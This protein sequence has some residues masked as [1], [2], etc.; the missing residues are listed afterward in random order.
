MDD[1]QLRDHLGDLL[2]GGN[3]HVDFK[4][5]LA[6]IPPNCEACVRPARPTRLEFLST[7]ASRNGTS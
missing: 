1:K 3:A 2:G 5:A 7:C 6:G 4:T